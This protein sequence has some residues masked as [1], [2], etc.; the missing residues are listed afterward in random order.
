MC[1]GNHGPEVNEEAMEAAVLALLR[2]RL[3]QLNDLAAVLLGP[4]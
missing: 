3:R 4:G 1:C 2:L